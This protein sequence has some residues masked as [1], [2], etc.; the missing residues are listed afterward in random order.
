MRHP[1]PGSLLA[2]ARKRA[3]ERL[4]TVIDK[5]ERWRVEFG[6]MD[7]YGQAMLAVQ[8]LQRARKILEEKA[9]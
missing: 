8:H 3:A 7:H 6:Y 5:L 1:V 4:T 9:Q 2:K